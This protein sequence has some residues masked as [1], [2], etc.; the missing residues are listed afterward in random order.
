MSPCKMSLVVWTA[1]TQ[2]MHNCSNVSYFVPLFPSKSWKAVDLV[3]VK[4]QYKRQTTDRDSNTRTAH[5][6]E[7]GRGLAGW[8]QP[9][10]W[11]HLLHYLGRLIC[12][13]FLPQKEPQQPWG[14]SHHRATKQRPQLGEA[15]ILPIAALSLPQQWVVILLCAR[16]FTDA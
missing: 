13:I 8:C 12:S 16:M 4:G 1:E 7:E 15:N 9:M 5:W 3:C 10:L 6:E 2:K 11:C 14:P